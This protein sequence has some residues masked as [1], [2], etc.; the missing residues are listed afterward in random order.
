MNACPVFRRR[1]R[2]PAAVLAAV[3]VALVSTASALTVL[4]PTFGE[5]VNEAGRILRGRVV[6]VHSYQTTTPTGAPVI[7]THVTWQV[8]SALKGAP[9]AKFSLDFLGGQVGTAW[10][11]VSGMP[12]FKVGDDDYLFIERD[13][14]VICP[15]IAAGHGRY[16]VR[17][18]AAT[19]REYVARENGMPLRNI[20]EVGMPMSEGAATPPQ[21]T[22]RRTAGIFPR[23][24]RS[25]DSSGARPRPS[26]A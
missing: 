5:L 16:R 6:E 23:R 25:G 17:T 4:P 9:G 19:G 10:L 12:Q 11:R 3:G 2:C 22:R 1:A 14:S 20:S 8:E 21:R 18:D 15:L 24:L 26:R 13:E 7:K